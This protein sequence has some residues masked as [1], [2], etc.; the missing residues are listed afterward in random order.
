MSNRQ[1]FTTDWGPPTFA[2]SIHVSNF[3]RHSYRG[4]GCHHV[5]RKDSAAW[6]WT[7]LHVP[8]LPRL[9][10]RWGNQSRSATLPP[11][12]I[13]FTLK[14]H[15]IGIDMCFKIFDHAGFDVRCI[16]SSFVPQSIGER[17]AWGFIHEDLLKDHPKS[18][19]IDPLNSPAKEIFQRQ[20]TPPP[21]DDDDVCNWGRTFCGRGVQYFWLLTPLLVDIFTSGT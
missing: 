18:G 11:T 17:A 19:W 8:Q 3:V 14:D 21:D 6:L 5:H 4:H 16:N 9:T 7:P 2:V 20:I 12:K 10:M 13:K 1:T 15:V